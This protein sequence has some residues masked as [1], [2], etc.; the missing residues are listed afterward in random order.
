[1][2]DNADTAR[3]EEDAFH[4]ELEE[5]FRRNE[6]QPQPGYAGRILQRVSRPERVRYAAIGGA[7]A[8]G[9]AV[10]GFQ[11]R[12]LL[13]NQTLQFSGMLGEVIA[14]AGPQSISVALMAASG[15]VL[16]WVLPRRGF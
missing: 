15:L 6:P 2:N 11:L 16:A 3:N 4:T 5:L 1:M 9:A 12:Q 7:G 14:F 8:L 13:E 10:S